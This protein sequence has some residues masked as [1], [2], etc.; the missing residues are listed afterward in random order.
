MQIAAMLLEDQMSDIGG[1]FGR[2]MNDTPL[3]WAVLLDNKPM[4][5]F[6][7]QNGANVTAI[8]RKKHNPLMLACI[9]QRLEIL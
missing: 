8:N 6:L 3:H 7:L 5:N 1:K 9:N 4:V 2:A